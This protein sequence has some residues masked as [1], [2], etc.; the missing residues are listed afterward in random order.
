M[1]EGKKKAILLI[2][3]IMF[4]NGGSDINGIMIDASSF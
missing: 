1:K 3:Y 2:N 4:L